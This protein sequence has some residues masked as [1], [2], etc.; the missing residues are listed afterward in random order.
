MRQI[1]LTDNEVYYLARLMM[2]LYENKRNKYAESIYNKTKVHL[3]E[4]YDNVNLGI[5][6]A[7][8][9]EC[10]W[11]GTTPIES[12]SNDEYKKQAEESNKKIKS[13]PNYMNEL[14]KKYRRNK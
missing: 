1:E 9:Y 7:K 2:S 3:N 6:F 8:E 4:I 13:E 11:V 12:P 10:Q 5:D 14:L